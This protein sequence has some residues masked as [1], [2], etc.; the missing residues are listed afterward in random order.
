MLRN[1]NTGSCPAMQ[2]P[3]SGCPGCLCYLLPDPF[4]HPYP[5]RVDTL[6]RPLGQRARHIPIPYAGL[7]RSLLN[8]CRFHEDLVNQECYT[9]QRGGCGSVSMCMWE[10]LPDL[11]FRF[12][13]IFYWTHEHRGESTIGDLIFIFFLCCLCCLCCLYCMCLVPS[14]QHTLFSDP[15]TCLRRPP[16]LMH[17]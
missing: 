16:T 3:S 15:Q 4:P 14:F 9:F 11:T 17:R 7:S 12:F 8:S 6:T 13:I 5:L 1:A 2:P 10:I